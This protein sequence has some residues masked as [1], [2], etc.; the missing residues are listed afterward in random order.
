MCE[1]RH[2][3]VYFQDCLILRRHECLLDLGV[4]LY[5]ALAG[6]ARS[7]P[8]K[9][10]YINSL[11]GNIQEMPDLGL[12]YVP[13]DFRDIAQRRRMHIGYLTRMDV[14]TCYVVDDVYYVIESTAVHAW[15]IVTQFMFLSTLL[16]CLL[17]PFYLTPLLL[18]LP[19][20]LFPITGMCSLTAQYYAYRCVRRGNCHC[21]NPKNKQI[22][23]NLPKT[24]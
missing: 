6:K 18:L 11:D 22:Y 13:D 19:C 5:L 15:S 4:P 8:G 21:L 12:S 7:T 1:S 17:L 20:A 3:K 9:R 10:W 14:W 2:V 23:L 16:S 24:P